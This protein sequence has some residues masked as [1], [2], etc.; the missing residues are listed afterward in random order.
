MS[1]KTTI[2]L[3][4]NQTAIILDECGDVAEIYLPDLPDDLEIAPKIIQTMNYL[5]ND[6]KDYSLCTLEESLEFA[7]KRNYKLQ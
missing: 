7:K 5:L 4:E 3:K 1:A 6:D 2:K